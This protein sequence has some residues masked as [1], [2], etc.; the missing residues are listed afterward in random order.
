M[1][2]CKCKTTWVTVAVARGRV[3][4]SCG[5]SSFIIII[6]VVVIIF[7]VIGLLTFPWWI[8]A[9]R[10]TFCERDDVRQVSVPGAVA[11]CCVATH[12]ASGVTLDL[13]LLLLQCSVISLTDHSSWPFTGST[14]VQSITHTQ[15]L[16]H[17]WINAGKLDDTSQSRDIDVVVS[18]AQQFHCNLCA[19]A[20]LGVSPCA[21]PPAPLWCEEKF[22]RCFYY[23]Y[24][25]NLRF[26]LS[27][28]WVIFFVNMYLKLFFVLKSKKLKPRYLV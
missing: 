25:E 21:W 19:A 20:Y 2:A 28:L 8:P 1:I 9:E 16:S 22:Y 17:W 13:L 10:W 4:V 27:N 14:H 23:S 7:V 3:V 26:K 12:I 15:S 24:T 5:C 6:V 11:A 18:L